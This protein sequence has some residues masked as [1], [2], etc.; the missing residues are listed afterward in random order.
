M[1]SYGFPMVFLWFLV[2]Y[3]WVLTI[4]CAH[5]QLLAAPG[6]FC[7][8]QR[9]QLFSP[10]GHPALGRSADAV[11]E[12]QWFLFAIRCGEL[13]GFTIGKPS[14]KH[15]KMVVEWETQWFFV[16]TLLSGEWRER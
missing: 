13:M 11:R 1:V 10:H 8:M 5:P 12:T 2:V 6:G 14:K 16:D 9:S 3:Q 4:S 7:A 15:G